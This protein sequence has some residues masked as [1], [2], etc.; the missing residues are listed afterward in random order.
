MILVLFFQTA[1]DDVAGMRRGSTSLNWTKVIIKGAH[2]EGLVARRM[3]EVGYKIDCEGDL[4]K[5]TARVFE[6]RLLFVSAISSR[7][8]MR[9]GTPM[10]D[11]TTWEGRPT[12]VI[13]N[14]VLIAMKI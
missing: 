4:R 14:W 12:Q 1:L 3:Y 6:P 11:T 9:Y 8:T 7:D 13:D 5:I 2:P 10:G